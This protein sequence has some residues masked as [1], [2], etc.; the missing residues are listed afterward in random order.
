MGTKASPID[1]L[2]APLGDYGGP[3]Q[4]MAL[5][6]G[7]PAIGNGVAIPGVTTDQRGF[8]LASP[9]PDIGAF[10]T[11]PL[12][13]NTT[14][15]GTGSLPGD[16]N[17]RQA[18]NL[19]NVT[20]GA[21]TIR[22]AP[23][24][25]AAH[26]TIVLTLGEL[27]LSDTSGLE[28][29]TG[30]EAGLT[31]DAGGNSRVFEIDSGV[32]AALSG[33]TITG[34]SV[35]RGFGGG[36]ENFGTV[37][38]T[39]CTVSGNSVSLGFGGGLGNEGTAT[40]TGC[41][42]S[43]N[44][45]YEGGG[46]YSYGTATLTNCTISGNS[47]S[48]HGGGL[49]NY[50]TATL[51]DC[52]ISGNST[53][54]GGGV[55]LLSGPNS[56]MTIVD[57]I[58]AGNAA[59]IISPD[60]FGTVTDDR[61]YNL[62]GDADGASGFTATGDQV[63]TAT[64]P[65]DPLLAPLGDYGGPTQT[66]ALLA[67]SPA[68][69]TG[70]NT[71]VPIDPSTG[72][73]FTTD[74][75]G[76]ARIVNGAVDIGAYEDQVDVTTPAN[77]QTATA[78]SVATVNLGSFADS[79]INPGNSSIVVDFGDGSPTMALLNVAPGSLGSVTHTFA[80]NGTYTVTVTATDQFSDS[81][82]GTLAVVVPAT[83]TVSVNPFN[84]TYGTALSDTQLSGTATATFGG[85]P[86]TVTG[87]LTY[88][89]AA[90]TV[91]GA[92]TGQ[93]EA[94]TFTPSDSIDYTTASTTV[95]VDVAQATPTVSVNPVNINYGTALSNGQLSGTAAATVGGNPVTVTGTFTYTTA[96]GTVLGAG[97]GQSEA[98]T[99]TPS[100]S[101]DYTTASATVTVN[102]AQDGTTTAAGLPNPIN[103][104][105]YGQ[106]VT[107][108]ATVASA[109]PAVGPPTGSV[110]F[111]AGATPLGSA[112]LSDGVASL[113][114]TTLTAGSDS[115]TAVYSGDP[116]FA[117]SPSTALSQIVA[118]DGTT[119]AVVSSAD[120]SVFGQSVTFTATIS[121][122][123]PGG[124]IPTGTVIFMDGST[125]LGSPTLSAGVATYTT[126]S[127]SVSNHRVKVVY[128][129]DSNFTGSVSSIVTQ[130]VTK[131]ATTTSV[132]SSANPSVFGQS[133]TFTAT[134]A[135]AAPGSGTPTGTVTFKDGSTTLGKSTLTN[136]SASFTTANLAVAT[137][138]ITVSYSGDASFTSSASTA[139]SQVVNQANTTTSLVSA[140]DPS[141]FGQAVT[142]TAT[143]SATAPGSGTPNGNVTFYDGSIS[144][145]T[146]ALPS[147]SASFTA[148]ALPTGSDAIVARLT[149][150]API[151]RPSSSAAL[152]Q[153]VNQAGTTSVVTSATSPS[154][155]GQSVTFTATVTAAAPG[156]GTPTG[157][158][159]FLDGSNA[160]GTASLSGGKAT[161]K[162][163][164]L[165]AGPHTITVSYSGD[166]NFVTSTSAP[167]AQTVNQAATTSKVTSS[168]NPSVFGQSVDLHDHRQGG[169]PGERH[170][171]RYRQLPGRLDHPGHR[172][173]QWR[174][175]HVL[176]LDSRRSRALDHGGLRRRRELLDQHVGH[177]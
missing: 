105:V 17:L 64:S 152:T 119:T 27:E 122:A 169:R 94:V 138:S 159:A 177:P 151:S 13:V 157:S 145:G 99:F 38:L 129:G 165:A 81:N 91:L 132:T 144:L 29:I 20:D 85:N 162:T 56:R 50:G 95:I 141:V 158:I 67:G 136:G 15:D 47:A 39:D 31:I 125:V 154:V 3:T 83:P 16:L 101:T 107:F 146:A 172:H 48:E 32:T 90:G 80:A 7:S 170:A 161:F 106:A 25:F 113:A 127:L 73:P 149:T 93:T 139:L 51:T 103:H 135:A 174:H 133:V 116:N 166:G 22:F 150:A 115:I 2:L 96:A 155:F 58:V 30:P 112:P 167:L 98:A 160:L 44:S 175:D 12:V 65:I 164:A 4:T 88:T 75:R 84:I 52:T 37:T 61:G 77:A 68:I 118:Q 143:V 130:S 153:S 176:D 5:R 108:T 137:Q 59:A 79:A 11:N 82:V 128:G 18:V 36:L 14:S 24:S 78:G 104:T 8:A 76:F 54:E 45:A 171:D 147:G 102:V 92:G 60:L 87:T 40:L 19:A 55:Y 28:T 134:V 1:P 9:R 6:T 10:Q 63:G 117:G 97:T 69:D 163:A 23:T 26:Q 100:D 42:V 21:A 110:T 121:P 173:A 41:T 89:T 114:V 148:K 53:N 142:F 123:A 74:Q 33:L 140:T 72:L 43:G 86:V 111:F 57:T 35:S 156:S 120:P 126:S 62:I 34:G 168:A 71:L 49:W 70:D 109:G 124:G 46:V 131:D 66:M